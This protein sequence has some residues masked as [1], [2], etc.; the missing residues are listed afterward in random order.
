MFRLVQTSDVVRERL[1][2]CRVLGSPPDA[3]IP[4]CGLL[5]CHAN[6]ML[7]FHLRISMLHHSFNELRVELESTW[8]VK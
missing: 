6:Q 3:Q 4:S 1:A 5:R 7:G 2:N 8:Y